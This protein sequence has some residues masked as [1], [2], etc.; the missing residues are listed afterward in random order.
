[1]QEG[2][3]LEGMHLEGMHL[4]GMHQ[5]QVGI[6][7]QGDMHQGGM[8][9]GPL[10]QW[11]IHWGPLDQGGRETSRDRWSQEGAQDRGEVVLPSE[12]GTPQLLHNWA[13]LLQSTQGHLA[14]VQA[15]V[16]VVSTRQW[17]W[18]F[19]YSCRRDNGSRSVCGSRSGRGSRSGSGNRSDSDASSCSGSW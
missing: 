3:H 5:D 7:A 14:L 13:G 12:E 16:G 15:A 18:L 4:E 1:M 2:M 11:G 8:H 9:W 10:D 17:V 6:L 19:T